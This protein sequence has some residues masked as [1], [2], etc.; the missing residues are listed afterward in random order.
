MSKK[1]AFL[2]EALQNIK[3]VGTLTPSSKAA[4]NKMIEPIDFSEADFIVE[5]GAGD[6]I[7]TRTLLG[8]MKAESTLLS[9]EINSKFCK[10]LRKID[11]P[12]LEVIED[13]A[14]QIGKYLEKFGR[15][16]ADHIVSALP[17]VVLPYELYQTVLDQVNDHLDPNGYFT[18]IQYSLTTRKELKKRFKELDTRFIPANLP[19]AVVYVCQGKA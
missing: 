19:P 17:L 18:Q 5:L 16:K 1:I 6:G 12:R 4:A 10:Q 3:T 13:S 7:V 15:E 8:R 9:F 2:K 11:D 14:C